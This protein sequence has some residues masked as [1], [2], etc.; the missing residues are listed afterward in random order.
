M[1]SDLPQT[2]NHLH[3]VMGLIHC[4]IKPSNLYYN[5]ETGTVIL[6]DFGS[7]H[8]GPVF[9]GG[10]FLLLQ[11]CYCDYELISPP[12]TRRNGWLRSAGGRSVLRFGRVQ[13]GLRHH[14]LGTRIF[15]LW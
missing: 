14:T 5:A 4:D 7:A 10:T 2:L 11:L 3:T 15:P 9:H 8:V 12:S 13:C 6:M 1:R